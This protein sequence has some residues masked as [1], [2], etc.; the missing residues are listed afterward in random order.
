MRLCVCVCAYVAISCAYWLCKKQDHLTLHSRWVIVCYLC[1]TFCSALRSRWRLMCEPA[2]W[3]VGSRRHLLQKNIYNRN[4]RLP[5]GSLSKTLQKIPSTFPKHYY[6]KVSAQLYYAVY[7]PGIDIER[8]KK[9]PRPQ[10]VPRLPQLKN[11]FGKVF[12]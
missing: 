2:S 10:T 7:S 1:C 12:G 8:Y 3:G 6:S 11:P 5:P 4:I 9:T